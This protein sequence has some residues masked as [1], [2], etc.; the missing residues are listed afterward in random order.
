MKDKVNL[1]KGLP[2]RYRKQLA[3]TYYD[4]FG[5]KIGIMLKPQS[6]T[7][8]LLASALNTDN[9]FYALKGPRLVGFL[10]FESKG[11]AYSDFN[12]RNLKQVFGFW[13]A[14]LV[15]VIWQ[16]AAYRG[17]KPGQVL[18]DAFAVVEDQRSQG[19]GTALF[20][21]F[22]DYAGQCGYR[23]VLLEVIDTNTRARKL[24]EGLGF[25]PVKVRKYFGLSPLLGFSSSITMSRKVQ[26]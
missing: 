2:A 8:K 26:L 16:L 25:K 18:I 5:S 9:G 12:Y 19:I 23:E 4:A 1:V 11:N 20:E 3:Q 17:L 10:G 6:K 22:L 13:K 7:I 21:A 15:S 14:A 24:Y